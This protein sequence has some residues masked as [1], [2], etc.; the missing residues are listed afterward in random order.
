MPDGGSPPANKGEKNM[1]F[2]AI[3][4]LFIITIY[5]FKCFVLLKDLIKVIPNDE[6]ENN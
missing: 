4:L 2:L 3:V 6:K 1:S 5:Q